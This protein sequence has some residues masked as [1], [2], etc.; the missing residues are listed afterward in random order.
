MET[1]KWIGWGIVF[2]LVAFV[3]GRTGEFLVLK[4]ADAIRNRQ[5]KAEEPKPTEKSKKDQK[6]K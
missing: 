3:L 2:G 5:P 6:G 1:A 4:L